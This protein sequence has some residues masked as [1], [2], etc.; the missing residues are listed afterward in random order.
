MGMAECSYRAGKK[1]FVG[2]GQNWARAFVTLVKHPVTVRKVFCSKIEQ[3]SILERWMLRY[4]TGA[5]SMT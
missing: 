4:R 1:F 2:I 5:D 3:R